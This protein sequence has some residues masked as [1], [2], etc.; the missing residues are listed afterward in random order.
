MILTG[1]FLK[2]IKEQIKVTSC[3][4]SSSIIY[5][6]TNRQF[7]S[8]E[9]RGSVCTSTLLALLSSLMFL[10]LV[11]PFHSKKELPNFCTQAF[12]A[13]AIT[14]VS[15]IE[16]NWAAKSG[17]LVNLLNQFLR[18]ER[19][20]LQAGFKCELDG[21]GSK[22]KYVCIPFKV[23]AYICSVLW[24]IGSAILPCRPTNMY[25]FLMPAILC[26]SNGFTVEWDHEYLLVPLL[27]LTYIFRGTFGIVNG[28]TFYMVLA[29]AGLVTAQMIGGVLC[30]RENIK[31]A[32]RIAAQKVLCGSTLGLYRKIQILTDLYNEIHSGIIL[33]L[34]VIGCACLSLLTYLNISLGGSLPMS[35]GVAC[36]IVDVQGVCCTTGIFRLGSELHYCSQMYLKVLNQNWILMRNKK[37]KRFVRSCPLLMTRIGN[38]NFIERNTV[39]K[40]GSFCVSRVVDLLLLGN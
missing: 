1:G 15:H 3:L 16:A 4:R 8:T 28:L 11:F 27:K 23:T 34:M 33:H 6:E 26:T 39:L 17:P 38:M 2:I 22:A 30:I 12:W 18:I 35:L 9:K 36:W 21:M 37:W 10:D 40:M 7:H 29:P 13:T 32:T 24:G 5:N 20:L 19:S 31:M 14:L 25:S